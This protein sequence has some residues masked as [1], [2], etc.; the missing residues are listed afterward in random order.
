MPFV[1]ER[2][3][4][5]IGR[6]VDIADAVATTP[7]TTSISI[8]IPHPASLH[9]VRSVAEPKAPT[10]RRLG[11]VAMVRCSCRPRGVAEAVET[12]PQTSTACLCPMDLRAFLPSRPSLAARTSIP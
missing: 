4:A 6:E 7:S 9:P 3:T 10:A 1:S 12:M 2:K 11:K 5:M 8:S